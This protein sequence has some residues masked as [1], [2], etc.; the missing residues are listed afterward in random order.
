[1]E[2]RHWLILPEDYEYHFVLGWISPPGEDSP[3]GKKWAKICPEYLYMGPL[4]M[5]LEGL[6]KMAV[7]ALGMKIKGKDGKVA[8]VVQT[9]LDEE[10]GVLWGLLDCDRRLKEEGDSE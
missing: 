1:M 8:T 2:N 6:E 3:L 7:D 10:E 4:V 9:C 5:P